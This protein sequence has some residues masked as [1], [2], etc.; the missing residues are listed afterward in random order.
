MSDPG[1]T[2]R[3][4]QRSRRAGLAVGLS[5][6]LTIGLCIGSFAWIYAKV[7]PFTADFTG[8]RGVAPPPVPTAT[9]TAEEVVQNEQSAAGDAEDTP[10]PTPAPTRTPTPT[11]E[12]FRAT[13]L[14]NPD[15]RTN[16]RPEPSVDNDPV[17]VLEPATP[18]QY[19]NEETTGDDGYK[20]FRFRTE[21]G[22]EGWM[23]EGTF[24]EAP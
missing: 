19:L 7:D 3:L 5:M 23:R 20:W 24:V 1:L 17:A 2:I 16:L 14:S 6:A 22:L 8:Q 13:H 9:A 18:L 15:L 4:R 12:T 21:D 10:T 11:P